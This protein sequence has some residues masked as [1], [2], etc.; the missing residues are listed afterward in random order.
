MGLF[1]SSENDGPAD[2]LAAN[3]RGDSVTSDILTVTTKRIENNYTTVKPLIEVLYEGKYP[4]R[5][6]RMSSKQIAPSQNRWNSLR[7]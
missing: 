4:K 5:I 2:E 7:N 3:A 1:G 6:S